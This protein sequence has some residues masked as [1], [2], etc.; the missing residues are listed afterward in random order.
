MLRLRTVLL[1]MMLM[2]CL[3]ASAEV[4]LVALTQTQVSRVLPVLKAEISSLKS[5]ADEPGNEKAARATSS[6]AFVLAAVEGK[7]EPLSWLNQRSKYVVVPPGATYHAQC[8]RE[9]SRSGLVQAVFTFGV[10]A[11]GLSGRLAQ[12]VKPEVALAAGTR[13]MDAKGDALLKSTR[14]F[15]AARQVRY[16]GNVEAFTHG[17]VTPDKSVAIAFL[18]L[19]PY[20]KDACA[21]LPNGPI[22]DIHMPTVPD[23][24]TKG[25]S[26]AG[27]AEGGYERSLKR[28]G[29][30]EPEYLNIVLSLQD[31]QNLDSD[32]AQLDAT[33]EF[34]ASLG[35][36]E[37]TRQI[38][39]NNGIRRKNLAVYRANKAELGALLKERIS[40]LNGGLN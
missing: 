11:G 28:A 34:T 18:E 23:E 29:L 21:A 15:Y 26:K 27:P 33:D 3:A 4:D 35:D 37:E 16:V 17:F 22:L 31:A 2:M 5:S 14:E 13:M 12:G 24:T 10:A 36:S 32:P 40:L 20:R 1:A 6:N 30:S 8:S 9:V 38:R 25:I 7:V 39:R 19:N